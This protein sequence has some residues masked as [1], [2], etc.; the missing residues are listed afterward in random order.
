M[1]KW[2]KKI[3]TAARTS[4]SYFNFPVLSLVE[5]T[6]WETLRTSMTA[7]MAAAFSGFNLSTKQ[8]FGKISVGKQKADLARSRADLP[9]NPLSCCKTS[10]NC[11]FSCSLHY[12]DDPTKD[13]TKKSSP[14]FRLLSRLA[15]YLSWRDK[16]RSEVWGLEWSGKRICFSMNQWISTAL[17]LSWL[18]IKHDQTIHPCFTYP[19]PFQRKSLVNVAF[20]RSI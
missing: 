10:R 8:R 14:Y 3:K 11:L 15:I 4:A 18:W 20:F 9:W 17:T 12:I 2:Q 7:S 6:V 1:F 5:T 13:E 19:R 16:L